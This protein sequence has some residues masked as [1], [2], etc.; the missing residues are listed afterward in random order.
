VVDRRNR[1]LATG[2]NILW[3]PTIRAALLAR[4]PLRRGSLSELN[5]AVFESGGLFERLH[6]PL[7][8][9]R[10]GVVC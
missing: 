10:F 6:L 9:C 3:S 4:T 2:R 5:S 1:R 8:C 7:D